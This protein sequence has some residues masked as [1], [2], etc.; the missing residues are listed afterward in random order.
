MN[1]WIAPLCH[2]LAIGGKTSFLSGEED[3]I[4]KSAVFPSMDKFL[5][6]ETSL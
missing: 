1:S 3:I 2:M 6:F 4:C 5:D